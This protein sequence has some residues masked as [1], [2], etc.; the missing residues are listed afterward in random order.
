VPDSTAAQSGTGGGT[1]RDGSAG[2]GPGT[3]GGNGSG[4]G[5]G[6]GSGNGP[7]TGG[8]LQANY[9]PSPTELF[10][11]PLPSAVSISWPSTTSIPRE[12]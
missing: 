9:P 11:P 12:R 10:I 4:T 7:G 6:R 1:G 3:G 2:N 5:T 8:G